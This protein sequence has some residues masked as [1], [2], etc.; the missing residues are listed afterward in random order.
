[1]KF[2]SILLIST[3]ITSCSTQF[4]GDAHVDKRSCTMKCQEQGL[5]LDSMVFMGDYSSGCV[6]KAA[7]RT[8][9]DEADRG[10]EGLSGIIGVI[11][12]IRGEYQTA[13]NMS[14][15]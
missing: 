11:E 8:S 3:F 13:T 2:F 14:A 4:Y 9:R 5:V 7:N 6:C 10:S 12:Q 15:I 1:M